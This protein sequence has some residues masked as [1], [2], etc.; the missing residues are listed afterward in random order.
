MVKRIPRRYRSKEA[1]VSAF[2]LSGK[3]FLK[4]EEEAAIAAGKRGDIYCYLHFE[5][6]DRGKT[7]PDYRCS[8]HAGYIKMMV[9]DG[10]D[11]KPLLAEGFF[12]DR[13]HHFSK[14][15]RPWDTFLLCQELLEQQAGTSLQRTYREH[16]EIVPDVMEAEGEENTG[17]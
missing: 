2:V 1:T 10:K 13:E 14:K 16:Y 5:R 4:H 7:I 17:A 6:A 8:G 12:P 9:H 15:E 11:W 3:I